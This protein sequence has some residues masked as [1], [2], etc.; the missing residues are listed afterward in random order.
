MVSN[1]AM[2]T[3][4]IFCGGA[5]GRVCR[6]L[7]FKNSDP[8]DEAKAREVKAKGGRQERPKGSPELETALAILLP[9]N[10]PSKNRAGV[11]S[12]RTKIRKTGGSAR[13]EHATKGAGKSQALEAAT[14][15]PAVVASSPPESIRKRGRPLAKDAAKA[16]EQTRP[17]EAVGMS[18]RTWYRRKAKK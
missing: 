18:R 7:G 11:G 16:L 9:A 13:S 5:C 2:A 6:G 10:H 4:C 8:S 15:N 3:T 14:P 1:S 17:W 12:E